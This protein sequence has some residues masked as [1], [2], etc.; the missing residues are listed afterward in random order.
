MLST[1]KFLKRRAIYGNSLC[2]SVRHAVV[3]VPAVYI[4]YSR[5]HIIIFSYLSGGLGSLSLLLGELEGLSKNLEELLVLNLL[6]RLDDSEVGGGGSGELDVTVLGDTDGGEELGNN[7]A[8]LLVVDVVRDDETVV[9]A[10]GK[11]HSALGGVL[12]N[13]DGEGEGTGLL[14]ELRVGSSRSLHLQL[15]SEVSL[16]VDGGSGLGGLDLTGTGGD[17]DVKTVDLIGLKGEGLKVLSLALGGVEDDLLLAIENVLVLLV[18]EHALSGG[19]AVGLANL[20]NVSGH[21]PVLVTRLDGS[22]GDLSCLPG[23]SDNVSDLAGDGSAANDKGLGD[24]TAVAVDLG[25]KGD[26]DDVTV[27]QLNL[28]LGI[29]GDGREMGNAV[30]GGDGGGES[31]TLGGLLALED[32]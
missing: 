15:V 20:G 21:V 12:E 29:S 23:G 10:L 17:K 3:L 14:L 30:V 7:L 31:N 11:T 26:L 19:A 13:S 8:V 9:L 4:P 27:L 25:T 2:P 22:D 6:V 1:H 18:G 5:N 28:G 16:L 32:L 24:N